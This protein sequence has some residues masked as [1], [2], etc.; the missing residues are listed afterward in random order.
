MTERG[1]TLLEVLVALL[2]V[3]VGLTALVQSATR[4]LNDTTAIRERTFATWIGSNVITEYQVTDQR[5]RGETSEDRDFAGRT[6][7]GS[8]R[9]SAPANDL[10]RNRVR[11][12]EVTVYAPH[13]PE[14]SLRVVRGRLLRPEDSR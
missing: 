10:L 13:N 9:V 14:Q 5:S 2:V 8:I 4:S 12:I 7:P 3:A 11:R 6:W 1:F